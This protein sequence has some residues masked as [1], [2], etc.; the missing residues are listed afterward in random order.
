[1]TVPA[2]MEQTMATAAQIARV[3]ALSDASATDF[4]DASI[5]AS[6]ELFP[7]YDSGGYAP[8]DDDWT[9][10]YDLYRAAA[11]IVEQRVAKLAT[12]YDVIAD[13]AS[14]YRSQM[15]DQ[16]RRLAYRLLAKSKPR[17]SNPVFDDDSATTEEDD[18]IVNEEDDP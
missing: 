5:T 13:G 10:T 8:T 14:M 15:Q 9:A 11:D 2:A 12:R 16:L 6:I 7:V 3:R 18:E 4:N 17:F 1:M